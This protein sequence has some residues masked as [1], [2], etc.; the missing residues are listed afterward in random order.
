M[1]CRLSFQL[2]F[3]SSLGISN[4]PVLPAQQAY[5][6]GQYKGNPRWTI[7]KILAGSWL[8]SLY[9][10]ILLKKGL[11]GRESKRETTWLSHSLGL[12]IVNF[13]KSTH[14]KNMFDQ[15]KRTFTSSNQCQ[16][17]NALP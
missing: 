5:I 8:L 17:R 3:L 12:K 7:S 9:L 10:F 16:L 6:L 2:Q 13:S 4:I 14:S 1:S 11:Q 15:I